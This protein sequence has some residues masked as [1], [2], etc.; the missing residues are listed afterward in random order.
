[1][2]VYIVKSYRDIIN[3]VYDLPEW[4]ILLPHIL[5]IV[6]GYIVGSAFG[7]YWRIFC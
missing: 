1:M 6:G 5:C 7:L 2:Q 3:Q 4:W